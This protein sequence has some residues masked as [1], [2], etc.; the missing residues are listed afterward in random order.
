M[1][2]PSRRLIEGHGWI[3]RIVSS[4]DGKV[5]VFLKGDWLS[6]VYLGAW[7]ADGI[8]LLAK[9][10]LTL[11]ENEN[12][13]TAWTPDSKAV[14]FSSDRN[15][16]REIF[17][18][19][20]DQDLPESLASSSSDDLSHPT[21][22]PDGSEILYIS[23]P[24]AQSSETLS[25]ILAIPSAGGAPRKVLKDFRIWNVQCASLS[26]TTCMYSITNGV[27]AETF[28]FDVK[29]GKTAG[30]LQTDPDCNWS[31]SPDGSQRAIVAFGPGQNTIKLRSTSAGETNEL[32][33]NEWTGLMGVNW[34][35]NG[36]SLLVSWHPHEW[37][38]ALLNIALNGKADVL[39]RSSDLEIW[40]AVPSPNG[41][42]LA[43][44]GASG[45]RNVWQ[46]EGF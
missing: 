38:S 5:L 45:A 9:R 16:R 25:S 37:D 34:S 26:S 28:R 19:A 27:T 40:H 46:L 7:A 44:A 18:Q 13:P 10:R 30:P 11:D 8:H 24:K 29:S 21:L 41:N 35:Q 4:A 2:L 43:I 42:W 36:K 33:V 32:I 17:K 20:I 39:I 31:L 15:G 3:S 1:S 22:T 12:I 23:T 14:L 6:S